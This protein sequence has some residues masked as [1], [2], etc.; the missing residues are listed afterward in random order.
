MLDV[1][2]ASPAEFRAHDRLARPDGPQHRR[3]AHHAARRRPRAST[4]TSCSRTRARRSPTAIARTR[5]SSSCGACCRARR[6]RPAGRDAPRAAPGA[7]VHDA[8]ADHVQRRPAAASHGLEM[9]AGDR[10]GLLSEIGKVFLAEQIDVNTAKI[11]TI[12]E[13]A[14]DVFYVTDAHGGPLDE[15]ARNAAAGAARADARP[16]ASNAGGLTM[17]TLNPRLDRLQ[18]V[19]VRTAAR[20]CSRARRRRPRCGTSR[21]RSASRRHAPPAFHRRGADRRARIRS[22]ATRSRSACRNCARRSRAGSS[23]ATRCRRAAVRADD[24]VLP[25]NGTREAL[26]SFVQAVVDRGRRRS[27][28]PLVLMPNPFYQIYEGAALLAGAEPSVPDVRPRRTA[29]LPDLDAVA[30]ADVGS[31]RSCCSSARPAIRPARSC[32]RPICAARSSSPSATIS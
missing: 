22:A 21:C 3:C 27:R 2:A 24:M 11:M 31:L 20:A 6:S 30:A 26:F 19:S 25:V 1:R 17:P 23:G 29:I 10:P 7:H 13:R 18:P 4:R 14:E 9:I 32:R 5:S 28:T 15:D 12:G 8:D 16:A